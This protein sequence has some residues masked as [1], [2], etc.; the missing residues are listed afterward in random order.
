MADRAAE[1]Q[2]R[3]CGGLRNEKNLLKGTGEGLAHPCYETP[4]LSAPIERARAAGGTFISSNPAEAFGGR[5]VAFL[6]LPN[7]MILELLQA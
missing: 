5:E 1:E 2:V 7:T 6:F 3:Q 4:N